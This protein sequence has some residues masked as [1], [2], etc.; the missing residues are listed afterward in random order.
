M[1]YTRKKYGSDFKR[2]VVDEFMTGGESQ[3]ALEKK[4]GIGGGGVSRWVREFQEHKDE[5]F[6]GNGHLRTSEQEI[7]A[8]RRQVQNLTEQV[9]VLK[10]VLQ[11]VVQSPIEPSS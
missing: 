8:L 2:M 1:M 10:K 6:P 5:A 9:T 4:Y 11:I 7:A 3:V